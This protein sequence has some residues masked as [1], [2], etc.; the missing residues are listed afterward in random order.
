V[1]TPAV[2]HPTRF[3][4]FDGLRAIAASLIVVFH[5]AS[6]PEIGATT[7]HRWGPYLARLDVGVAVFFVISGF[8]LYR[9]F[10]AA[11]LGGAPTSRWRDFWWRRALRIYPAYWVAFTA[12]IVLFR[13][14]NLQ[15]IGDYVRYYLLV[16]IYTHGNGL[17]GI[18]P[19]WSLAVEVSFYAAVPLYAWLVGRL[20]ARA[21]AARVLAIEVGAAAV[22]Y[23]FGLGVRAFLF[24]KDGP[25]T[26][27]AQWLPAEAD[28]FALGIGL[29]V[30]S[31][32]A[33]A[34]LAT[35]ATDCIARPLHWLGDHAPMS[36]LLS[37]AAFVTVCHIGLPIN[38]AVGTT[39]REL[40]H[41]VL[42]GLVAFFLVLPAVFG[43]QDHGRVRRLLRSRVASAVGI[44]SYGVFLWHFDWITKLDDWGLVKVTHGLRFALVLAVAAV[45]TLATAALSWFL[46]ERPIL[47]WKNRPPWRS[48]PRGVEQG[49]AG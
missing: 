27:S 23:A 34:G 37:A 36:W 33:G 8:L 26:P 42:Y 3:P 43:P 13:S 38:F 22:L 20:S 21:S 10:A 45:L 40:L 25:G 30:F 41:Q 4:C 18:K 5:V 49:V 32:A 6:V 9:P 7:E 24:A 28:L 47:E 48:A 12:A 15:G 35:R 17:G 46:V 16:Q 29:A 2:R 44:V 11:H 1:T 39:H 31:A 19:T 14:T